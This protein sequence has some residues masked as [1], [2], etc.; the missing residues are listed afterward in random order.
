MAIRY[1]STHA[2]MRARKR[3]PKHYKG[4]T[5]KQIHDDLYNKANNAVFDHEASGGAHSFFAKVDVELDMVLV[6]KSREI[7]TIM[8]GFPP[9]AVLRNK[10]GKKRNLKKKTTRNNKIRI[11]IDDIGEIYG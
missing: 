5:N 8:N 1:I 3:F 11:C 4:F 10:K 2:I 6:M 7:V 9:Q